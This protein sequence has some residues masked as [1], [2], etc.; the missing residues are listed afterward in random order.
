MSAA[1]RLAAFGVA[2]ALALTGGAALGA[3]VGPIDPA[4]PPPRHSPAPGHSAPTPARS[5]P[6]HSA[7]TTTPHDA[8]ATVDR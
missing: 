7:P 8:H 2:A 6:T 3:A 1:T 4:D 5:A